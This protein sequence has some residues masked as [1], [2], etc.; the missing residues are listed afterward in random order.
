[1]QRY[2]AFI[3]EG[4]KQAV[5]WDKEDLEAILQSHLAVG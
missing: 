1:V 2:P 4:Q 5:G 3:V